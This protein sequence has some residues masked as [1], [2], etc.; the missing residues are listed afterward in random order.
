MKKKLLFITGSMNQTTQMQQIADEMTG[1][2]CWFSQLFTDSPLHN[3]LLKHTKIADNTILGKAFKENAEKYLTSK[4]YKIDYKAELNTY[5]L[6]VYCS[7]MVI[8]MRMRHKKLVWVQEGM[9]DPFTKWSN[10]V[11][12]IYLP[13]YWTGDTSLNGSSN[14]CD[15]YC[16]ASEGY[17]DYFTMRGTEGGKIF[18]TGMPNYDNLR[19][20]SFNNFS[21]RDYV[22]VATSDVRETYRRDNRLDFI[23]QCVKIANGRPLLFK[24]H[25][26]EEINRAVPEIKQNTPPNTRVYWAGNTN[27]MIANCEELITQYSTVV[28]TGIALGKRVYSYF[29]VDELKRLAPHQNNG[30]SAKNIAH[31]VRNFVEFDGKKEDF[32]KHFHYEPY[33]DEVEKMLENFKTKRKKNVA[34]VLTE[35][36]K[37]ALAVGVVNG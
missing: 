27:E 37:T 3:A 2:D 26:N 30:V 22:M 23:K 11:K 16:A 35:P 7:D 34:S 31:I 1:Y 29:D 25:P 36:V 6:V 10:V 32:A 14:V 28:Y 19:Q 13:P 18:V 21:H 20:S 33:M 17:K 9:V 24:L 5:D 12:K 15:I 8:P 4:G